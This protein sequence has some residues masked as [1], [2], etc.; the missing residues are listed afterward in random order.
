VLACAAR[1]MRREVTV[2]TSAA[3]RDIAHWISADYIAHSFWIS[4]WSSRSIANIYLR[5]QSWCRCGRGAD[6]ADMSPGADVAEAE[7][8]PGVEVAEASPVRVQTWGALTCMCSFSVAS[9]VRCLMLCCRCPG[10]DPARRS[11]PG[12]RYMLCSEKNGELRSLSG[13]GRYC[14]KDW[15]WGVR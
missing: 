7:P 14:W 9:P 6:V 11:E 1:A 13:C 4:A 12:M 10:A 3:G 15:P 5:A 2:A 8:R